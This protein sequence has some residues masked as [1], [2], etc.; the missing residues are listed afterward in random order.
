[1]GR[2]ERE[3]FGDQ[4]VG[5]GPVGHR[6]VGYAGRPLVH[7]RSAQTLVGEVLAS[8]LADHVG[9][10]HEGVGVIHHYHQVG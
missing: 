6:K 3:Q 9:S 1:M 2:E 4:G 5:L 10:A 8:E 7:R